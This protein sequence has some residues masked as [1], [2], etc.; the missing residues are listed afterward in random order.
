MGFQSRNRTQGELNRLRR[1]AR[2]LRAAFKWRS[3]DIATFLG[4]NLNWVCDWTA[5]IEVESPRQASLGSRREALIRE[6]LDPQQQNSLEKIISRSGVGIKLIREVMKTTGRRTK[7]ERYPD[8]DDNP[9]TTDKEAYY[10][11]EGLAKRLGFRKKSMADVIRDQGIPGMVVAKNG[12]PTNFYPLAPLLAY[13]RGTTDYGRRFE[14]HST[15]LTYPAGLLSEQPSELSP[16]EWMVFCTM[17]VFFNGRGFWPTAGILAEL[18]VKH[19]YDEESLRRA[20][21]CLEKK[22]YLKLHDRRDR[23]HGIYWSFKINASRCP[24]RLGQVEKIEVKTGERV[25]VWR[26]YVAD[27]DPPKISL[28]PNPQKARQLGIDTKTPPPQTEPGPEPKTKK[29]R[30][31][32]LSEMA[33][34]ERYEAL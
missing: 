27:L 29:E 12:E 4:I 31:K 11:I 21:T 25:I 1:K 33:R 13:K 34:R 17:L 14:V 6:L 22:R 18:L 3:Q 15:R 16:C 23:T 24:A 2:I 32:H 5:D 20:I 7:C 28:V 19:R 10:D 9:G 26:D 30:L 8:P